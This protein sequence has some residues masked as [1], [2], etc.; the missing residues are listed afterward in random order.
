MTTVISLN[1]THFDTLDLSP[2]QS[3]IS[4]W[5]GDQSLVSHAQTLQFQI[6][7]PVD[8]NDPQ[9]WSEIPAIRLWFLRLD[10]VYPWLP[11][12][13]DWR[14]GEL[15]RYTAMLVPHEFN[16]DQGIQ[17]NPQALDIFVMGKMF[18]LCRWLPTQGL[19]SD[20]KLKQMAEMFG[21]DLDDALF[22]LLQDH[23]ASVS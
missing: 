18:V 15:I 20:T 5:Q 21:Y 22:Q 3:V 12:L 2:A 7:Y 8:T 19:A 16:A 1:A 23:P 11:F 14:A 13:L 4:A 6:D 17:F 10:T 9:E